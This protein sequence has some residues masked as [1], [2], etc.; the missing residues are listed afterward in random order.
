MTKKR[1][2]QGAQQIGDLLG[3]LVAK[4]Q[5]KAALPPPKRQAKKIT[6]AGRLLT[7]CATSPAVQGGE[8]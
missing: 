6:P 8:G 1:E 5:A 2:G 3:D 4:A 7:R